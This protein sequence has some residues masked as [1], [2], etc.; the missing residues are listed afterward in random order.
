MTDNITSFPDLGPVLTGKIISV[1]IDIH[2][3]LG[4]GLLESI[5]E[6]CLYSELEQ[7]GIKT[8]R[9]VLLPVHYKNIVVEQGFR[10][11]LWVDRKVVIELKSCEKL[12]PVHKAQLV[13]YMKLSKS[14][15]GL[16]I[17]FNEK[18]LKNGIERAALTEFA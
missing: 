1:A 14:P 13:T 15:L 17:N 3:N 4:P 18:L 5:Y 2:K 6:A 9:Q 10:I 7:I 12:L 8:E 11:D 16:L